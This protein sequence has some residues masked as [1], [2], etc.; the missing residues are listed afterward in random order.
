MRPMSVSRVTRDRNR[1][2][3]AMLEL[4]NGATM[5]QKTFH[6]LYL[7]TPEGFKAE[8]IGGVVYVMSSPVT[9]R[10]GR[11]HSRVVQWL[12]N[13]VDETPGTDAG[14]NTTNVLGDESEPQP[15][16]FLFIDEEYGGQ[17]R[18]DEK[19]YV[20]GAPELVAEVTNTTASID[21]NSKKADYQKAGV[22][23]YVVFLARDHTVLWFVRDGSQ[24]VELLPGPDG[25]L[26]SAAFPGLWLDPKSFFERSPR[27]FRSVAQ[28]GYESPEHAAFVAEMEAKRAAR[29]SKKKS[30]AKKPPKK[31]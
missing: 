15:D 12:R 2:A 31:K 30:K 24:F 27:R 8:L 6:A 22:K 13:Y 1:A 29:A 19:D 23:E 4:E 20:R 5:D 28:K 25:V 3:A 21:L 17:T 10:H 18:V 26:K 11:P 14:D 9:F 7:Q 16:A